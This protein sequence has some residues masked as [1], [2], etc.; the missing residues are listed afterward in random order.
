MSVESVESVES[1]GNAGSAAGSGLEWMVEAMTRFGESEAIIEGERLRSYAELVAGIAELRRRLRGWGLR[2][3]DVLAFAGDYSEAGVIRFFAALL[4]GLVAV[5]LAQGLQAELDTA[6]AAVP[7][8]WFF[9]AGR[10]L[11]QPPDPRSPAGERSAHP[12][13]E[14]LRARGHAGLIILTSGST[15]RPKVILH[16]AVQ[17][18]DKFR[19]PRRPYRSLVFLLP[20]HMG[21]VNTLFGMLTCGST[22]ILPP[23]REPD[24]ICA[25]VA[26]HRAEVLPVTPSFL[27]LLLL[28][29]AWRRSDLSSLRVVS[30]GTE[31]MPEPTLQRAAQ[32]LPGVRFVQLYGSSELG[33][34]RGRSRANDSPFIELAGDGFARFK[35]IDGRLWVHGA[36]SM[37]G[38]LGAEPSGF[39]EDGWYD[40]GDLVEERDGYV[41]FLGRASEMINVGGQKVLPAEVEAALL[42]LPG[43]EEA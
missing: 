33:I 35:I 23:S 39:A 2:P 32:I 7:T 43:V 22:A 16:D 17:L 27:N 41:R 26:K 13:L 15:G 30:Y 28:S 12:L 19:H 14:R 6:L 18:L 9:P 24:T 25:L 1:A 29:E 31:V 10:A 37:L 8:D 42:A 38:Y 20:D 21:G 11:D 36:D 4:E 5:P 3:G 34:F 40:T